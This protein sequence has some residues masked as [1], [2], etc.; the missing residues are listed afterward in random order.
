LQNLLNVLCVYT[1]H[2]HL[3]KQRMLY[4]FQ[5]GIVDIFDK[6]KSVLNGILQRDEPLY[7]STAIQKAFVEVNERGTE[8]AAAN[9]KYLLYRIDII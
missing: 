4:V 1:D 9:S 8:A 2:K 7:V 3:L 6:N 5:I